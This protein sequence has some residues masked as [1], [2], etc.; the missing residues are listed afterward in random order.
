MITSSNYT[1]AGS[2]IASNVITRSNPQAP[3]SPGVCPAGGYSGSNA[4]SSPD[5][6]PTDGQCYVYTLTGTDHVGNTATQTATILVDTTAPSTPTV[7]FSGL[8]AG[9]TYDNGTGTLFFRPSAA[10]T[11]TVNAASTDTQS[12]I[13]AGTAGYTFGSLNSNGGTNFGTGQTNGALS[14]TFDGTTTGP[15]TQRTVNSTNNANTSSATANYTVTQDSTAPTGGAFTANGTAATGVGSSSYLT[16]G[17]TLTL[18]GRTDYS[19]AGSGIASSTLTIQSATLTGNTCGSYGSATTISGTTSQTVASG[20]CY[21]LTL[22]GTDFVG[23]TATISTIVKVDTTAPSAPALSFANPTGGAYYS[24]SGTTVYFRPGAATG[25]FDVTASSTDADTGVASYTFPTAGAMGSLWSIAGSG[26]TRTYSYTSGAANPG[27]QS[28]TATNNAGGTS[29]GGSWTTQADSAAP[30]GGAF[31]ANGTAATGVGSTS[32]LNSGTTL[33]LSGRSDYTDG[34]SGL[35]GSILTIAVGRA[36]RQ[37]LRQL[38]Q[39]D[40]DQRHHLADRCQRQLL[41]AHPHRHRLRR[42]Q[43]LGLHHRHGRHHRAVRPDG[44]LL[45][46]PEQRLLPGLRL[47]RLLPGRKRGR[48]HRHRH[49]CH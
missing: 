39:R 9:N 17:T 20:N 47:D 26:A 31:S 19:D 25:G 15:T 23:N 22:T 7:T 18:S 34:G 33:T 48:L 11:F 1:D 29:A 10:G 14:V 42:Q 8:S 40:D 16:S 24:G 46:G 2:G 45:H 41:P 27:S 38:R 28:V 37:Q 3:S 44:L 12:D 49:R 13:K 36:H 4:A 32:Y 35:A 21:L 5:T 30:T 43:R 6:V